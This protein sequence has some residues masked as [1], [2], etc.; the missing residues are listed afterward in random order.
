M[1]KFLSIIAICFLFI[2]ANAQKAISID[3]LS[4]EKGWFVNYAGVASDT[5]GTV[6]ATTFSYEIPVNK[7]D[8]VYYYGKIKVSDKTTGS[9]GVCT[10][11]LQGKYFATDAYSDI[12]TVSWTGIGSTDSTIVFSNISTKTFYSYYR[13]LVTNTSGKSKIDYVKTIIKK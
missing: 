9:A 12:T 10:V 1:K 2:S 6:T 8:G 7:F 11:K 13:Y 5:L 3:P 4:F